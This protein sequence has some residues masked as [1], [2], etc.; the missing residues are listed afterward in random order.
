MRQRIP[1]LSYHW[2]PNFPVSLYFL[3][4]SSI[5]PTQTFN[6]RSFLH[7]VISVLCLVSC[8]L[9]TN[10]TRYD[11]QSAPQPTPG[12]SYYT[13]FPR[14]GTDIYKTGEFIKELLGAEDL[15]P[16]PDVND[17]LMHWTVEASPDQVSHCKA[18]LVSTMLLSSIRQPRQWPLLASAIRPGLND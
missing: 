9:A 1:C 11:T 15:L 6:M 10:L 12:K 17:Q 7:F 4:T 2:P 5:P 8:I 18:I 3:S 13:V 14:N 16:W